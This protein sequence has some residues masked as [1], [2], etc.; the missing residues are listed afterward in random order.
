[1]KYW[2]CKKC[3]GII[4]LHKTTKKYEVFEINAKG[5]ICS[6]ALSSE[7]IKEEDNENYICHYCG[8]IYMTSLT[9]IKEIAEWREDV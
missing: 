1:M 7:L 3:G 2:K 5:T 9:D 8:R 4:R 6:P